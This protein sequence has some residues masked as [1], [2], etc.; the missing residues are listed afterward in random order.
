[1][2]II[3]D[4]D[5]LNR[6]LYHAIMEGDEA[7]VIKLCGKTAEGPL[8]KMTIHKDTVIHVA[9]DAKRSDLVLKLLEVLPKDHDP[10]LL[11]VKNDVENT[12]LHEAATDSCLLPAAEEM[13]RRAPELLTKRNVYG[14]IPLF[15]A[16]RNGEKKMFKFLVGEVEKR[17]P[18]EEEYL[19]GIFQRKDAT[20]I[21]HITILAEH[22][23]LGK[24][25]ATKHGYISNLK[26]ED[27]MIA[28]Q[29][30]AC[31]SSAFKVGREYGFLKHFM[32]SCLSRKKEEDK[33]SQEDDEESQAKVLSNFAKPR[34]RWPMLEGVRKRR[35]KYESAC[36]L[37]KLLIQKDTSW[38]TTEAG[39]V[40][41]KPKPH[42]YRKEEREDRGA[43]KLLTPSLDDQTK[44]ASKSSST[45]KNGHEVEVEQEEAEEEEEEEEEK[46]DDY[47]EIYKDPIT[48]GETPLFLATMCGNIE[49]VEEILNVHPQAL[50]HINKKGRNILHVA[51]KYSQKE[52][53]EL[54]M[55][56]EILARRLITR[57]DK[58]GN[59]IL[60]MAARKKKKSYLAENIQ[61]PALQLRKELLLFE[62]VRAISPPYA[63]KHLNKK[64]QTPEELFATTYARLHT[65]GKEWIKRTSENCTIVAVLIATV[66]F[67]A[68]YTIPGGSNQNTGRPILISESLFVVFTLTDVLSL[69]F[70]LTSVVTFLSILTSSFPIQAFRQSLPQKLMVG[71][72]L[73]ILS[74]TMMMV[75]FGA[76]II[77][78]VD[79][80]EKWKRIGLYFAAFFP[81]TIFAISYSS[82]YLSLLSTVPHLLKIVWKACPR[83]DCAPLPS[84][85]PKLFRPKSS[86][87]TSKPQTTGSHQV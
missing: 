43:S 58:F 10:R 32:S 23:D 30:L 86:A 29:L 12:I 45:E 20:T 61:S 62:R 4:E 38:K 17:G 53:F 13:L 60:H 47:Q 39:E 42:K 28:L 14:E 83:Y 35:A 57:T 82:L 70:A 71:L 31:D 87:W 46:G 50:E 49:I 73:L 6:H 44:K 84:W 34:W 40:Q 9:C 5:A 8:H 69:T 21:L 55:K 1:M 51:I 3:K 19:K 77:L 56:K 27:G 36:D 25:I 2:A 65:Y 67:A 15:C 81:V 22:Y 54:V 74:V 66:A 76:T 75:A 24:L 78:M 72:T 64:K 26:D 85:V 52:I 7:E 68:A 18:N 41:S 37:A 80:K 63:T 79:N 16:A 11:T 48:T 33:T 59:T